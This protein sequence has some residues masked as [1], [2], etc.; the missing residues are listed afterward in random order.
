VQEEGWQAPPVY[1]QSYFITSSEDTFVFRDIYF[2]TMDD[3]LDGSNSAIRLR[4]RWDSNHSYREYLKGSFNRE[5]MPTR[6]E[7]QSKVGRS[8]KG[9][10]LSE[11]HEARMEFAKDAYPIKTFYDEGRARLLLPFFFET[12]KTG[13]F[14]SNVYTPAHSIAQN[15]L[16]AKRDLAS[17]QLLPKVLI[18]ARRHRFHLNLI[19]P[20]GSGPN[21][22]NAFIVTIDRYRGTLLPPSTKWES[23]LQRF[24]LSEAEERVELEVEF[25]RNTSTR[26]EQEIERLAKS[27]LTK[28]LRSAQSIQ[29]LFAEDHKKLTQDIIKHLRMEGYRL[30]PKNV[31]KS[32]IM[33]AHLKK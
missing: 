22:N 8:E 28:E 1:K 4:W 23:D 20:W 12:I 10:G 6:V 25:E 27:D 7:I 3:L 14:D 17:V 13:R 29:K 30:D 11:V 33:K 19:T 15:I 26:L 16:L 2:D 18:V 24:D 9:E 5:S 21:P 31:S 32:Q